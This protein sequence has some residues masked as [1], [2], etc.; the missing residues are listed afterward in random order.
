M[1]RLSG[2][3]E[4][5]YVVGSDNDNFAIVVDEAV[6]AALNGYTVCGFVNEIDPGA[7]Q[8]VLTNP[9]LVYNLNP[10]E[11]VM[12]TGFCMELIDTSD[13]V[14]YELGYTSQPG[15]EGTFHAVTP[16]R[17]VRTGANVSTFQGSTT[18]IY[19]PAA[20]KY[21]DGARSITF[22]VDCGG[23]GTTI[24]PAWHGYILQEG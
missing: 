1:R 18:E 24:T 20:V 14:R 3:A 10:G 17:Y 12:I 16:A 5:V 8:V 15:G 21:S 23:A 13:N 4:P 11:V 2:P 7:A 22:R 9:A 19:P 6:H